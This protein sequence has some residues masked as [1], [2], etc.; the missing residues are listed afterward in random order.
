MYPV[1]RALVSVTD[2]TG[3]VDFCQALVEEF[4]VELISTGG[5]ARALTAADIPVRAIED[6]TG[7]PEMLDGRVKTLHPKVHGA[8]LAL[9][10]NAEHQTTVTE[11]GIELIDLVCV[12]LYAF[13]DRIAR[14]GVSE[15]EAVEN[16]DIGG[17]SMLRSAAKNFAAVT[18]VSSPGQYEQV[19][20]EMR[21]N[22]GATT[23]ETRRELARQVFALTSTYDHA[24]ADYLTGTGGTGAGTGGTGAGT[25]EIAGTGG[26]GAVVL[27]SETTAPVPPALA[28][29]PELTFHLTKC[30]DLRYGE[31][32]HQQAAFYRRD[33]VRPGSIAA[34]EQLNGKELSYNNLLDTDA[35][36]AAVREFNGP[37]CAI[38]KHANPCGL[39]TRAGLV[40]AYRCAWEADPVSA[41]GGIVA[42]NQEVSAEVVEAIFANKQFVEVLVA[43]SYTEAALELLHTKKNMRVLAT[44]IVPPPGGDL[45]L[46]S[47][48]GGVLVQTLDATDEDP[49]TFTVPTK[50]QP[51]EDE[52]RELLFAWKVCK[53]VKSNAIVICRDQALVGLGAGQPNRV[54]S[55]RIAVGHA[56]EL[57][58]EAVAASD[59]FM[60]F[61]DSLEVLAEAGV[62][63]V[64]Q[65]GGS[66]RDDE[67]IAAADAAGVALL[68]TGHRHFRH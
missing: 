49:A 43:P 12:N 53:S 8:L 56:G 3:L 29:P 41:Y 11:R 36:W 45:E 60:P 34:A 31:N 20:A 59:A 10:D 57:A 24:I 52:R 58:R 28:V 55:A 46:R 17:P 25:G 62:T 13:E 63:A 30:Q 9:R 18:V 7:T 32:P 15:A 68:F 39:A 26:V 65:P 6:F 61:A 22:G 27:L 54:D 44:G 35:A 66:I 47:T 64:I 5:T 40:D 50:R 67:V 23:R 42:F 21:S 19:L 51:T 33:D 1:K 38:I 48:S 14:K 2:K 16:I 37:A 4:G